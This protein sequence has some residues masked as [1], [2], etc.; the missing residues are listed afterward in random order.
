MQAVVD[1]R[2]I[3]VGSLEFV[4]QHTIG[5][6]P[7]FTQTY[8]Q[9]RNAGNTLVVVG[10]QGEIHGIIGVADAVKPTSAVAV[11]R[12][13]A[14]GLTPVLLTGDNTV[15]AHAIA[16]QVG[17]EQVIAEVKPSQKA[18]QVTTLQAQGKRVAMVGDGMNDAAALA[19][20]DLGIAMGTGTDAAI[21]AA[22]LTLIHGDLC[23]AADAVR[24]ARATLTTIRGNLVW[25]FGY[26]VV[27]I[28]LAALGFLTPMIAGAAM[29]FSSVLVVT[30][31]LRLRSFKPLS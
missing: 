3:T 1:G 20:A 5:Q 7:N 12:L 13:K 8:E 15:T 25:A 6:P 19:A 21:H 30:N 27:A 16:E 28:P 11:A 18:E 31:S 17:I 26:N 9:L 24:L 14:L 4:T 10:W 23:S 29:A 22:D 2:L